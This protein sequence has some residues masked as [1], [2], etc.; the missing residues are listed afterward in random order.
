M[1]L[2][3]FKLIKKHTKDQCIKFKESQIRDLCF[4]HGISTKESQDEFL[5]EMFK[6]LGVI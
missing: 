6:I 4:I 2:N 5:N 1:L 3:P